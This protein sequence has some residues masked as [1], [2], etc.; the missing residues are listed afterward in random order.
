ME[1]ICPYCNQIMRSRACP[2]IDFLIYE[3]EKSNCMT[4][5][6]SK[7]RLWT[8]QNEIL[9]IDIIFQSKD[10]L[11]DVYRIS[12]RYDCDYTKL[13]KINKM[14]RVSITGSPY[15]FLKDVIKIDQ[16]IKIDLA[17]PINSGLYILNK[18][19]KLRAFS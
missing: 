3:C 6:H 2:D 12:I 10:P 5:A 13:F 4:K 14:K 19:L 18:L 7:Y 9:G 15:Y 17:D 1:Y 8:H 16:A 11:K